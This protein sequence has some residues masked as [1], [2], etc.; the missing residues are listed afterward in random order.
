MTTDLAIEFLN[1][2][3]NP[4]FMWVHYW[5]MHDPFILPPDD[6]MPPEEELFYNSKG[7]LQLNDAN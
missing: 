6:F 1:G 2:D 4:F 5:D 3:S 7:V